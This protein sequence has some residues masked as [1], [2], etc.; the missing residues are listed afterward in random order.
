[1]QRGRG[2]LVRSMAT[3]RAQL[4]ALLCLLA[5]CG[6]GTDLAGPRHLVLISLDTTR[7]DHLGCYGSET[8]QTPRIDAL[9]AEGVLFRD[10]TAPAPTT[11]ASHTSLMTGTYPTSHGILRN[12]F[13]VHEDNRMLAEVLLDA[14]FLTAGF[15]GSFALDSR[16]RFDQ[17][18][19]HWDEEFDLLVTPGTYDQNQ[20]RAD[21]VTDAALAFVGEVD[22][23]RLFLFVHYFDAHDP[24]EPPPEYARLY[25]DAAPAAGDRERASRKHRRAALGERI[26]SREVIQ[27]G[28]PRELADGFTSEPRVEDRVLADLYAGELSFLDAQIGRLLDGLAAEGVLEDALVVLTGD[29]GETFWEH[30]DVWNHG[31][32]VYDTTVRVPLILRF[33]DGS[34]G[35]SVVADSVS[36][37]DVVPTL[38]DLLG[39]PAPERVEGTSLVPALETGAIARGPLFSVATQPW[40]KFEPGTFGN[41]KNPRCVRD[42]RWKY[43]YAPYLELEQLFDVVAD[44]EERTNLLSEITDKPSDEIRAVRDRLRAALDRW[45]ES[46]RPFPSQLDASQSDETLRRLKELGYTGGDD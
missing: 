34:F 40:R 30:G 38:C 13:R 4:P 42:G 26:G 45:V 17:G 46:A 5:G 32:W 23:E 6:G 12:G 11:L 24:Y 7:A 8:V 37:V 3:R 25:T 9:A 19:V 10:V 28:L 36:T 31:L 41:A 35:G 22:A 18:F 27:Q 20:R 2:T 39:I 43:V 1:M 15:L 33:G 16:F 44:P 29:H 21:A 14:G